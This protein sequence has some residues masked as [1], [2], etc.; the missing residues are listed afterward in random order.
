MKQNPNSSSSL[1]AA[2]WV[3]APIALAVLAAC[4]GSSGDDPP[5]A[6]VTKR[7]LNGQVAVGALVPGATVTLTCAVGGGVGTATS[8]A[9]GNFEIELTNDATRPCVGQAQLPNSNNNMRSVIPGGEPNFTRINFSPLTDAYTSYLLGQTTQNSSTNPA[10]LVRTPTSLFT[11]LINSR[12]AFNNSQSGFQSYVTG[13]TGISLSGFDFLTS[14]IVVGQP[15]DNALEALRNVSVRSNPNDPAS[16]LVPFLN[17]DGTVS[18]AGRNT[19]NN[20]APVITAADIPA[21]NAPGNSCGGSGG[22]VVVITGG[23]GN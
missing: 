23:T 4:G 5:P 16:P 19:V 22:R 11:Q 3:V 10:D 15:S 2:R 9:N 1:G 20:D 12:Q 6:P 7:L 14:N 21:C 13:N 8:G 17:P 18:T